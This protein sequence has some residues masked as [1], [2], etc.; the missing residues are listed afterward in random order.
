MKR[1]NAGPF[2]GPARNA[3][4]QTGPL[5]GGVALRPWIILSPYV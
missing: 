5:V 4:I 2:H 1:L 3:Y